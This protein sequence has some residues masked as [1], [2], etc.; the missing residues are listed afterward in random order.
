[1][2]VAGFKL[3]GFNHAQT[4]FA[5]TG[6]HGTAMC[7]QC[8]KRETA[9]FP[10]GVGEAVHYKGISAD[11]RACH[12]DVHLGQLDARCETCH[13]STSFAMPSYKHRRAAVAGLFV[14]RHAALACEACH[15]T[16]TDTFPGG[17][18]TAVRFKVD[19]KC[20]TCHTDV[21]RG[22]LGPNCAECHRL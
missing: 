21:H 13:T 3:A 8:H 4:R 10:S 18:G 17:R 14:G 5:L 2:Q 22:A 9:Q 6:S 19:A 20:V 15:K 11:C 1:V 16:V 7:A 12:T